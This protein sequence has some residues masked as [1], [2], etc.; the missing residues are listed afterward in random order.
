M[1][2]RPVGALVKMIDSAEALIEKAAQRVVSQAADTPLITPERIPHAGR[3]GIVAI[4][5]EG[6]SRIPAC[7]WRGACLEEVGYGIELDPGYCD[8]VLRRLAAQTG[9]KAVEV[10]TGRSFADLVTERCVEADDA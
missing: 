1:S 8:V 10:I 5:N 2:Q 6:P 7:A 3:G 4:R 9:L